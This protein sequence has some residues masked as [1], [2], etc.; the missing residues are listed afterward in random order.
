MYFVSPSIK[1]DAV[2]I[3]RN[4]RK[5][6]IVECEVFKKTPLQAINTAMVMKDNQTL[7]LYKDKE[8]VLIGLSL[9]KASKIFLDPNLML[10]NVSMKKYLSKR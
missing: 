5:E 4:M 10:A 2:H 9:I 3:A 8:P 7:T 6:D 1:K